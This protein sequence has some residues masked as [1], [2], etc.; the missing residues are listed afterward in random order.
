MRWLGPPF[1]PVFTD[2]HSARLCS[3]PEGSTG[4]TE[5]CS[6]LHLILWGSSI[7]TLHL[8]PSPFFP[9]PQKLFVVPADETQA[10]IPYAR[11]N[12]NKYMVTERATYI[13]ECPQHHWGDRRWV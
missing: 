11:V 9:P 6:T 1:Q 2:T 13:G 3:G 8:M 12:H 10:R 4:S 5:S 7:P